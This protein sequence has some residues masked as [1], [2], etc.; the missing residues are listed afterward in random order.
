M[1]PKLISI[2]SHLTTESKYKGHG[3]WLT[4]EDD[5]IRI[6][7]DTYYP[8]ID[9]WVKIDGAEKMVLNHSGH[10]YN[11]EYH[12]GAWEKYISEV[13]YPKAVEARRIKDEEIKERAELQRIEKFG[14]IDDSKVFAL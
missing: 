4:Y 14:S 1:I 13:L 3:Y 2:A 5:K 12:P 10:G 11:E 7:Y 9:V 6:M 8:N